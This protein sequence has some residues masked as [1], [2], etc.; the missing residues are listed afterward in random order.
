MN[1][2]GADYVKVWTPW[3]E[4]FLWIPSRIKLSHPTVAG[5]RAV[6]KWMWLRTVYYRES[7]YSNV[8]HVDLDYV[9]NIEVEYALNIF[10]ILRK[11]D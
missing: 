8:D 11:K 10:D 5:D 3:R 6:Y 1:L 7:S 4:R 9:S 2:G